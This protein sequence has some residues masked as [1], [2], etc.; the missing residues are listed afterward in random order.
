MHL[1]NFGVKT[2]MLFYDDFSTSADYGDRQ[3]FETTEQEQSHRS[4]PFLRGKVNKQVT[5][6]D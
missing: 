5:N 2:F 3:H 1:R 6:R 4:L